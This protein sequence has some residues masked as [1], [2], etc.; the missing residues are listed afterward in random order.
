VLRSSPYSLRRPV[1]ALLVF[2]LLVAMAAVSRP[3]RADAGD[4]ASGPVRLAPSTGGYYNP[5]APSA[6]LLNH[7]REQLGRLD[8]ARA[9]STLT[10]SAKVMAEA[11]AFD[12][13][14]AAGFPPAARQLGRLEAMAA[15]TG[16]S[17]RAFKHAPSTQ[18]ARL[19][20]VLVEFNPNANDDFSGFQRPAA[21]GSAEC[22]TEPAGTVKNGPLHNQLPDPATTGRGTD[23]NTFWVPDFSPSHY[24]KLIYTKTGLT[25]RVRPDLTGPD[26]RPGI[27]LRGYTVKN[28]YQEMS[29]SA[30][31]ITGQAAGWVQVPHSEA[32]YGAGRCGQRPQDNAGH[33][34]NA[35]Q[36]GQLVVDA[37]DALAAA[38]PDFPWAD[39]DI[40]DQGDT[41]GDGNLFEP[42]GVIDHFVIIHAGADKAAGGGAEG[43]YS[44]WSHASNVDPAAGGYAVP[45]TGVR[46]NNYIMQGE[47]A[48]VGVI[49]HEYG[50]DLGLPDLYDTSGAAESDVDFWDLMSSG[51]HTGPVFQSI[52][53]HMG[54]WDKYVLG[55]VD[56]E[57]LG[58]GSSARD[59]KVGQTSRTPKGTEDGIRVN[60]PNKVVNRATPHS[61]EAM[62]YSNN[63]QSWADVKLSRTLDVP[64]GADVRFWLWDNYDIEELWDYGFV[65]VSTDGESTWTQLEVRD[66]AGNVVST[67]D[68][69][70]GNLINF[71][72]LQNGLTGSTGGEWRHD[73]VDLTPYAG[74]T[75]GLRLRYATDAGFE[76]PGWFADDFQVTAD[77]TA[78][79]TDDVESGA[80]GWTAQGG[81]FTDTS[82]AGWIITS[83]TFIYQQ[84]YLAEWR[85]YDGFDEGLRYAY[86]TTYGPGTVGEWRVTRTPY[87]APGML[88][89][90]RDAQYTVNHVTTPIFE[91]PSTGSK[92]M[93]LIV[94]SHF[95]PL[96]RFGEA[97]AHDPTTLKNLPSRAQSS[98]A[99]FAKRS[100]RQFR[101]CI[102]DP[103]GSYTVYCN[104]H[105]PLAGVPHF[106]DAQGWYPG[107]EL[108]GEDLFFRDVDASVVVPSK[109]NRRY[110]TRIV[111]AD[112]N[113]LSDLYGTDL[114]DGIILG[115]GNPA[116]GN[117]L[118]N[119]VEDLSLGV[120]FEVRRVA[121]NK[122]W[123]V[124][125]IH[126][127]R[128]DNT[129]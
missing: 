10:P 61:G 56:P 63:D 43:T 35:R 60:L 84:Y 91:L 42:D 53:V 59:V 86:D 3:F 125:A 55:W 49:S 76:A 121:G 32:W 122:R 9:R 11:N 39:Y 103:A 30:Y 102:E 85:N 38:E 18:T 83:G 8:Q 37:V 79:L 107:L 29:K 68:D 22:V 105:A 62:W 28:H 75:I 31:D 78:V 66:E 94:D 25:Q 97:A 89:W 123:V 119:P 93:L 118:D 12:R 58:V 50:H 41:D 114:G 21:I 27:D 20:T 110:T 7:Q 128:A 46:V 1:V 92:G 65:E 112:G 48:G 6:E 96:R 72:G 24:N 129:P 126:A 111:D 99:A 101:E 2:A 95:D 81:T 115:S 47:A 77:G 26:G 5:V 90:Y 71:G 45:G 104:T 87:N 36:V 108:R 109:D 106:T 88:V 117:P 14:Q 33:P 17:P 116:D 23:N 74:G 54:L 73:W 51:S 100:T 127:A 15:R 69:P 124:A 19:L 113:P 40:E 4:R 70:N 16:K 80:D 52:P 120:E 57:T 44:I 13:K 67:N 34:S 64:A 82:G 98:N